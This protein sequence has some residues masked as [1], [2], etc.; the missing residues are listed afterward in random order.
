[1][2]PSGRAEL[3]GADWF[4][5]TVERMMRAAG[6]GDHA[7]LSVLRLGVGFDVEALRRA[8]ARVAAASPIAVACLKKNPL[9]VPRW[10]WSETG[11]PP[12]ASGTPLV[13]RT[14]SSVCGEARAPRACCELGLADFPIRV[15]ENAEPWELFAHRLLGESFPEV[16]RFEILPAADG[17]TTLLMRWRHAWLDGKGAELLLAEIARLAED[18]AAEPHAESWGAIAPRAQGWR[19]L[20]GEAEKFKDHFYALAKLG[21][22][23]LGGAKARAS[24]ARFHIEEFTAEESAKI[25]ARASEVS[26]GMFQI[27]W[28]LAAAMRAHH[29]ILEK[30]GQVPESYQ[31]GC[32]VQE[33]KRGARH[34]IWQNQVSQLFFCLRPTQLG[35]LGEA[36]RL[37]QEQFSEMSRARLETA[38]AVMARLFRRLP[39]WFYLRMLRHNSHG[40]LT[41]FFFSHTGEFLPECRTFCG[42]PI[43]QGWHIPTVSQPPGSGIFFN[44]RDGRL[45]ATLS[46]REGVLDAAELAEMRAQ[47]RRDLLGE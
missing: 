19:T 35:D 29:V 13:A 34:P 24:A 9:G 17:T 10:Q 11:A 4:L 36:A 27:G 8:V 20:R 39:S 5:V 30:R 22:R 43:T 33:R 42:A 37:L 6:Q 23:S 25:A 14:P 26:R 3:S 46:W 31:S 12:V 2:A 32:A 16:V 45:S 15:H 1:M 28:F 38:F 7:A 40:H 44:Q 47:L 21:L 18:A 41:S